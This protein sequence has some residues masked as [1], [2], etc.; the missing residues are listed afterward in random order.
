MGPELV[1]RRPARC[2]FRREDAG[3]GSAEG[4]GRIGAGHDCD[5]GARHRIV[6]RQ[7][8][9]AL[10]AIVRH[11]TRRQRRWDYIGHAPHRYIIQALLVDQAARTMAPD[12]AALVVF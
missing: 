2:S 11:R 1:R 6:G 9:R 12:E 5:A 7:A 8:G 4:R 10:G 3:A